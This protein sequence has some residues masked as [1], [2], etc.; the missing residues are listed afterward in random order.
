MY[1][2]NLDLSITSIFLITIICIFLYVLRDP[3]LKLLNYRYVYIKKIYPALDLYSTLD[4]TN[5]NKNNYI[6]KIFYYFV[7]IIT[8]TICYANKF[9]I[10]LD[11]VI[12]I[13]LIF[14]VYSTFKKIR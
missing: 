4:L 13:F 12:I 5:I 11:A 8:L 10:F 6:K 2:R 1:V 14:I 9:Y 3:I 7:I